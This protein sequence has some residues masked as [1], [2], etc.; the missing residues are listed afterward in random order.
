MLIWGALPWRHLEEESLLHAGY[1]LDFLMS[2]VEEEV[3]HRQA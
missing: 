1:L 3:V 2:K